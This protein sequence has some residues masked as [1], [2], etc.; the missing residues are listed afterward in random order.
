MMKRP[1]AFCISNLK[2]KVKGKLNHESKGFL[3]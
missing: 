1:T 3:I 2:V